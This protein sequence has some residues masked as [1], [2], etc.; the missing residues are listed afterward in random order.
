[1]LRTNVSPSRLNTAGMVLPYCLA[2]VER[3]SRHFKLSELELNT[4]WAAH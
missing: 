4:H 2:H 1:M 3:A